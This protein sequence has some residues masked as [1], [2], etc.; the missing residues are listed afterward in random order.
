MGAVIE[1]LSGGK[2]QRISSTDLMLSGWLMVDINS[3]DG[4]CMYLQNI[5]NTAHIHMCNN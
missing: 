3:L 1:V 2:K 5:G 4:G